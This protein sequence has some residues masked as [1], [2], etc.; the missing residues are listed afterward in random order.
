VKRK[1]IQIDH[2]ELVSLKIQV[3]YGD[4]VVIMVEGKKLMART[5]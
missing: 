4:G 2:I 3:N 5:L 1:T